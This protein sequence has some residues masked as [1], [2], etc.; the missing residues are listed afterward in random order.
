MKN[1]P[2]R[3]LAADLCQA[4]YGHVSSQRKGERGKGDFSLPRATVVRGWSHADCCDQI[5][6]LERVHDPFGDA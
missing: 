5:A 4:W 1:S 2:G 3:L 6:G